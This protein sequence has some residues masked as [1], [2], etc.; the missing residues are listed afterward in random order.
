MSFR[1]SYKAGKVGKASID[2][3]NA[4]P[5]TVAAALERGAFV[6]LLAG[7]GNPGVIFEGVALRN[8]TR[9]HRSGTDRILHIEGRAGKKLNTRVQLSYA[10]P[11]A[12]SEVLDEV[13]KALALPRGVVRL[14]R[15]VIFPSGFQY[16]GDGFALIN[17]LMNNGGAVASILDGTFQALPAARTSTQD[18]VVFSSKTRNLIGTPQRRNKGVIETTALIEPRMRPGV[19][20]V[21]ESENINGRH[22]ARDVTFMG[23]VYTNAYFVRCTGRQIR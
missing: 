9:T 23:D 11:V 1:V 5:E 19:Q 2:V 17:R 21:I 4:A 3:Y 22:K 18:V 12:L 16:V 15:E 7:Y 10:T 20:Y 8:G 14:E 6:R 13:V